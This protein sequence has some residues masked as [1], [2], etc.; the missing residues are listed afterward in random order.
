MV[1]GADVPHV[2]RHVLSTLT[3]V[4]R[5]HA[6]VNGGAVS[7]GHKPTTTVRPYRAP[8]FEAFSAMA[9]GDVRAIV[10]E[11]VRRLGLDEKTLGRLALALTAL[12]N[13][14]AAI[15]AQWDARRMSD[16]RWPVE[17]LLAEV[18]RRH[19]DEARQR[20]A[21]MW[22]AAFSNWPRPP[23]NSV[24]AWDAQSEGETK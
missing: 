19:D 15:G 20:H 23:R 12:E 21:N 3:P 13:Y 16:M 14:Y 2:M 22:Q 9:P 10:V 5:C 7:C 4:C 24:R 8:L 17:E 18:D 1:R 11:S 6:G